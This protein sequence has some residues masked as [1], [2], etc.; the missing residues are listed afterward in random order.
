MS[1][2]CD[3]SSIERL[4]ER[5]RSTLLVVLLIN[6]VMFVVIVAAALI[7]DSSALLADSLDNFGD[8]VTYALSLAAVAGSLRAKARVALFKGALILAAALGVL[9]QVV[10]R[11]WVPSVPVFELM[12]AFSLVALV[13]N[14][15]CLT[16]LWRHRDED[17]NMSSVWECSRNDIAG[18]VAVFAAA[19]GVWWF[20]AG[21]PDLVVALAL[22]LLLL[23]SGSG[24]LR[25]ARRE[26]A[27]SPASN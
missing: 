12:G 10:Y 15:V 18:N 9:G 27:S 24:I 14:A 13:A 17:I 2:C 22:A 8:A 7:A 11:L 5:Q 19:G 23:R 16:L 6:A 21:W 4:R 1:D 26:L 20:E 25:S 3:V